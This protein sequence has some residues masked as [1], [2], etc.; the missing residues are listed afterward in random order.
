L[1]FGT[2]L[3][4][5]AKMILDN[6]VANKRIELAVTKRQIILE[7]LEKKISGLGAPKDFFKALSGHQLK[8]IAE[9]KKASPSKGLIRA[10]FEPLSIARTYTENGA[11]ALSVLTESRYFMGNLDYLTQIHSLLGDNRPPLLRK[12]FIL[13]TYQVYESRACGADAILLIA[14]IL[15]Y[16]Q[17]CELLNLSHALGMKCLAEIHNEDEAARA[18]ACGA[19]I[20]GINNR[21]LRTFEVNLETT[22]RLRSLIPSGHV[23]VSE[24]GIKT[25]Q[26][27]RLLQEWGVNAALVGETLMAS[28]DIAA[29]M[30]ELL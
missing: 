10:D 1:D 26:D 19:K 21:D 12:D 27:M 15:G 28:S 29:K 4:E 8:L 9:V 16:K 3:N 11:T 13:E 14:A 5:D 20:I 17:L 7:V 6:I 24:S 2:V 30:K 23:V 25:R 22:A 18:I